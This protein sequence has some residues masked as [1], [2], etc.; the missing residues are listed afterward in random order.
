MCL[1]FPGADVELSAGM[2]GQRYMKAK[3][4]ETTTENDGKAQSPQSPLSLGPVLRPY[5]T[6]CQRTRG[7]G[8]SPGSLSPRIK[9]TKGIVAIG[10]TGHRFLAE[11]DKIAAGVDEALRRI[12]EAFPGK[13]LAVISPLAEG[14]D[15]LV[16]HRVLARPQARLFVPLPLPKSDYMEDFEPAGSRE[17]FLSLFE[18]ANEMIRLPPAPTRNQAY[19]AVGRYVLDHCDV[20]I[21]IWDRQ[22]AQGQGGT[23]AIVAQARQ[24]GLP[25]AWIRAGNRRPGTQE[26]MILGEEQ[27]KVSFERFPD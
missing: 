9:E 4:D 2:D 13:L 8:L 6:K 14:A 18:R 5:R 24:R 20:L 16:V 11:V 12:E 26:P 19:E 27:G 17:A 21:A 3:L 7:L 15:R 22:E 1:D 23:A 25:L 10:V